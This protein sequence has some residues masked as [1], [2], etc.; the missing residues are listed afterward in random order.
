MSQSNLYGHVLTAVDVETTG[1]EPGYHEIIQVAAVPLDEHLNPSKKHRPLYLPGIAPYHPERQ[2]H[3][4]KAKTH[5]DAK[6]LAEEC[7]SQERAAELM[8]EW[9]LSLELPSG[10][11][12]VPLAHNWGFERTMML[13]WLGPECFHTIWDGRARDSQQAS[14]FI[15]DM[16][17]WQGHNDPFPEINLVQVCKRLGIPR[18][19]ASNA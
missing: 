11:R 18:S 8:D 16:H 14:A 1:T 13:H 12:L 6:K 19:L 4:A 2:G 3:D 5:L 10:K 9:F 7:I 17:W 15:N